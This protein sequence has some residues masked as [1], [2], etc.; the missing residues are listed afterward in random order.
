M[1]DT[2][3]NTSSSKMHSCWQQQASDNSSDHTKM[4]AALQNDWQ[5]C[6]ST[7][8][9]SKHAC[10]LHNNCSQPLQSSVVPQK[11]RVSL[12]TSEI[13]QLHKR[14]E[15]IRSSRPVSTTAK[16]T[17]P[18]QVNHTL[19]NGN[20]TVWQTAYRKQHLWHRSLSTSTRTVL[21]TFMVTPQKSTNDISKRPK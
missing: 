7:A 18:G 5:H 4:D 17:L 12:Q 21:W 14:C 19:R 13:D 15:Q 9:D 20:H 1:C 2:E 11:K 8:T 3:R 6:L 16:L 10:L